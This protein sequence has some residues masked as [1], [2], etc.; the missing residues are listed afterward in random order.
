MIAL[1]LRSRCVG[2]PA[3]RNRSAEPHKKRCESRLDSSPP[4]RGR[5]GARRVGDD[6]GQRKKTLLAFAPPSLLSA[7]RE[8]LKRVASLFIVRSLDCSEGELAPRGCQGKYR[9][10]SE[11]V[12]LF[13]VTENGPVPRICKARLDTVETHIDLNFND[14]FGTLLKVGETGM[15]RENRSR[16]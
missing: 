16:Q 10:K 15:Q 5:E 13:A 9:V 11:A 8:G 1:V 2:T 4:A 6:A 7:Q 14:R 12:S 3:A